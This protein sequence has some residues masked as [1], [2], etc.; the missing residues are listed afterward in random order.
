M[1]NMCIE[2]AD[3]P[4]LFYPKRKGRLLINIWPFG[5]LI[6]LLSRES[7]THAELEHV[8]GESMAI[9]WEDFVN[10]VS[11]MTGI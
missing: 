4:N 6:F 8:S 10:I 11:G 9:F 7:H 5:T 3:Q 2:D 1:D